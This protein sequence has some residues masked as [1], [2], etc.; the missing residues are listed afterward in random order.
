MPRLLLMNM[1]SPD[2][3]MYFQQHDYFLAHK[4]QLLLQ[5]YATDTS[6][7]ALKVQMHRSA[8]QIAEADTG[9]LPAHSHAPLLATSSQTFPF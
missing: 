3:V 2:F 6:R 7:A 5:Y 1:L 4:Q 8:A 9:T